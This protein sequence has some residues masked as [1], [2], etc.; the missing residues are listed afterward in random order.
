[1]R[2]FCPECGTRLP[3]QSTQ[4]VDEIGYFA[5]SCDCLLKCRFFRL[6][7]KLVVYVAMA[8]TLVVSKT[9]DLQGF[10]EVAG[11]TL[12]ILF[13]TSL[14]IYVIELPTKIFPR[15]STKK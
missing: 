6:A 10:I 1:M 3:K 7:S 2:V 4:A 12:A 11:A 15:P 5:C 13:L 14:A 9:F 8:A